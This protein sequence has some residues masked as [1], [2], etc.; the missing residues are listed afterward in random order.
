[1]SLTKQKSC[2]VCGSSNLRE[3]I[4]LPQLPLTGLY[5][6]T[7]SEAI[8]ASKFDQALCLCEEC[9]HGQL[10]NNIDPKEVYNETY[11]HRSSNST[12]STQANNFFYQYIT[13]KY[14]VNNKSRIL[15]IGCNDGYLLKKLSESS[16]LAFGVDPIWLTSEPPKSNRFSILGGFASDIPKLTPNDF[17]PNLVISAH[18]FEHSTCIYEDLKPIV[19]LSDNEAIFFIE[20]PSLDSLLRLRRFD[21]VFHQHIQYISEYSISTLVNRLGCQLLT[22][23]YNMNNWGGTVA[24][25]FSKSIDVPKHSKEI[26][27]ISS[28]VYKCALDDFYKLKSLLRSQLSFHKEL[29][30][31]GAAQMLS[32]LEYHLSLLPKVKA[33]LDDN[34]SRIGKYLGSVPIPIMELSQIS[35][36]NSDQSGYII[37]AVDSS[38]SLISRAKLLGIPNLYSLYQYLV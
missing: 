12:I 38:R 24:F 25:S 11:T 18:T 16:G 35:T 22:I 9:S 34:P 23:D 33:I 10:L 28:D 15:E 31:I 14:L 6:T 4:N 27:S 5:Y 13:D 19:D 36:S 7:E 21:Q 20:M 26:K 8:A 2:H 37:G 3:V 17:K 30:Y 29:F 1:M 32:V